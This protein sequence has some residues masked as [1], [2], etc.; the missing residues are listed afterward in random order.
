MYMV[1]TQKYSQKLYIVKN[2]QDLIIIVFIY[3]FTI[4]CLTSLAQ[5]P[6][7]FASCFNNDWRAKKA[8]MLSQGIDKIAFIAKMQRLRAITHE[9]DLG[10]LGGVLCG[11]VDFDKLAMIAWNRVGFG[12]CGNGVVELGGGDSGGVVGIDF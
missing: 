11:V 5:I 9:R 7:L 3:C 4:E 6:C 10:G 12:R 1:I 2:N 8:K